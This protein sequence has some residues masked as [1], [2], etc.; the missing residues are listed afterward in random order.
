MV[1]LSKLLEKLEDN[2]GYTIYVFELLDNEDKL[3]EHTK[4]IMC[5]KCPNWETPEIMIDEVGYLEVKTV[6]A[7]KDE[8]FNGNDFVKYNYNNIWFIKFV[9][10]AKKNADELIIEQNLN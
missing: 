6:I 2:L 4:F 1:V 7:G 5:T 9:P 3:R 10:K 8:W